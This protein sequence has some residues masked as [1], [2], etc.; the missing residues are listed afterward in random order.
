[1][2]CT[3]YPNRLSECVAV[4]AVTHDV[5]NDSAAVPGALM[6]SDDGGAHWALSTKLGVGNL[7]AVACPTSGFCVAVGR[8]RAGT[9]PAILTGNPARSSFSIAQPV[10]IGGAF[11]A[12][13]CNRASACEVVGQDVFGGGLIV[14]ARATTG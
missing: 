4:G 6:I 2:K 8:N 11:L 3:N 1:M 13:T 9:G 5:I 7:A 12:V 10:D 14:G